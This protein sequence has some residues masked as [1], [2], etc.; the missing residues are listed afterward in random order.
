MTKSLLPVLALCLTFA[1][2]LPGL[3][4]RPT[5]DGKTAV[6]GT[7]HAHSILSGDVTT[8]KGFSP[9]Q[10]FTYVRDHGLDFIGISDHH[11]PTGS[12]GGPRFTMNPNT[13]KDDL[14]DVAI[15]FNDDNAG[16]FVALPGIEWGTIGTGNHVNIFGSF[17]LPRDRRPP[18][19]G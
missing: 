10:T 6:F 7:L 2:A 11:K 18:N 3:A 15:Q 17:T 4:D 9:L 1:L 19:S 13:Y 12:P 5:H 16:K 14:F 8:T